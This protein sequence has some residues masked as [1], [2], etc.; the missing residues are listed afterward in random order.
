MS[1]EQKL[2][3]C[4]AHLAEDLLFC[5]S[6]A[7]LVILDLETPPSIPGSQKKTERMETNIAVPLL[8]T[9]TSFRGPFLGCGNRLVRVRGVER[10]GEKEGVGER[11]GGR[12]GQGEPREGK[13]AEGSEEGGRRR[14]SGRAEAFH[15]RSIIFVIGHNKP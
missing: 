6:E 15:P 12:Q 5:A 9:P 3:I 1:S 11:E 13:T 4:Q 14:K 10:K 8:C 7:I 2:E